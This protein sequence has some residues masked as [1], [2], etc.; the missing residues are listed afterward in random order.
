MCSECAKDLA[1]LKQMKKPSR[2][3]VA[4][5]LAESARAYA[6]DVGLARPHPLWSA[7][8]AYESMRAGVKS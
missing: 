3:A 2:T 1:R 4:D 6:S 5:Q 7:I 8:D